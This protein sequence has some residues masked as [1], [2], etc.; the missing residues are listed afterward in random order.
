MS[1][2]KRNPHPSNNYPIKDET[3]EVTWS[4][5]FSTSPPYQNLLDQ[6]E[7]QEVTQ[8]RVNRSKHSRTNSTIQRTCDRHVITSWGV[9]IW[10]PSSLYSPSHSSLYPHRNHPNKPSKRIT[11][12][13]LG[14]TALNWYL[15]VSWFSPFSNL[16]L[17]KSQAPTL[18]HSTHDMFSL[19]PFHTI[20]ILSFTPPFT[21]SS[22]SVI[23]DIKDK[24]GLF[25][26]LGDSYP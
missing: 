20:F 13:I 5:D 8:G 6:S 1:I 3:R 24:S 17:P 15:L 26:L 11:S 14:F 16:F 9:Y 7:D 23:S 2:L 12:L 18:V 22:Y 19:S 25:G 21:L 4:G 10:G